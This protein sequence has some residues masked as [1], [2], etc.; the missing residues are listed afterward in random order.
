MTPCLRSRCRLML[1]S[2]TLGKHLGVTLQQIQKYETGL[3][4]VG[5]S[6][7]TQIAEALDVPLAALF[8]ERRVSSARRPDVLVERYSLI[9]MRYV[10]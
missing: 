6:R 3:N 1:S 4:R 5:A 8:N 2:G 7:L 9:P 10:C